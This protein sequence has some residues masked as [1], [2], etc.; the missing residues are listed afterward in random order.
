MTTRI[1]TGTLLAVIALVVIIQEVSPSSC[2][3][4]RWQRWA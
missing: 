3:F 4:S 2:S 1:V